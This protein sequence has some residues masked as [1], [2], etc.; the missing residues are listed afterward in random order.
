[1]A[2]YVRWW[3]LVVVA[4]CLDAAPALAQQQITVSTPL[5]GVNDRFYEYFNLGWGFQHSSPNGGWF[6]NFGGPNSAIPPFG[7]YD[8]SND[9]RF[10]FAT[11]G[12]GTSAF[13]D[14]SAGTGSN[15]SMTMSAPSVTMMNG[16]PGQIFSGS[17]RPFVT[18]LIPVVG[19]YPV[20]VPYAP[21]PQFGPTG[22]P[23]VTSPLAERL[24]R[25][26]NE[27]PRP[28]KPANSQGD[29][30]GLVLGGAADEPAP[31]AAR[32]GP[33]SAERGD[34]SVAEIKR[35]QALED[36]NKRKELEQLIDEAR[37]AERA[38][39]F[40]VARVHYRQAAARATGDQKRELLELVAKLK[41]QK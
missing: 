12:N 10:G 17:L 24:E 28:A 41:P 26:R 27:P 30:E 29:D 37:A 11:R 23:V 18:G 32:S 5:V 6:M 19:D 3:I 14:L 16:V 4:I 34:I 33:S 15:R 35:S 9:L 21:Y 22:P 31:I 36:E 38:G 39:Q 2:Q 20:M 25:L 7:G 13:F 1:M 40:G 8:P